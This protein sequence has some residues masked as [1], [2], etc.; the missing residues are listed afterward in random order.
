[1]KKLLTIALV[2][3]LALALCIPAAAGYSDVSD[4]A[5]YAEAVDW[6]AAK[7]LMNGPGDGVF[8]PDGAVTRGTL[9]TTLWRMAGRPGVSAESGFS[10]VA[11]QPT[12]GMQDPWRYRNKGSFPFGTADGVV[13]F[14]FFA[15]R[16]H[17]LVP[18]CDCPIEDA[19]ITAVA[20][21]VAEWATQNNVSIYN[22]T[23][24][25]GTL[26][27]CMVRITSTGERMAY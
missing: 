20:R 6:C 16:S 19:R 12:V 9:V 1:M 11:V 24:G 3:A 13:A 25:C 21:T 2:A 4:D 8:D 23:L 15:E 10:D 26:R 27:A 22:E 18:L 7:G 17:R 5:W 14:G